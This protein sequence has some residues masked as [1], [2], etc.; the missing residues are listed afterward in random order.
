MSTWMLKAGL[1]LRYSE[2][3]VKVLGIG[4]R[5]LTN[6]ENAMTTE[7]TAFGFMLNRDEAMLRNDRG[8]RVGISIPLVG[9]GRP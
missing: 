9:S 7:R 3:V 4:Q 1:N 8:R 6:E 5:A 2:P